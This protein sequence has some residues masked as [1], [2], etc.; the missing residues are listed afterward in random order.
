MNKAL[1]F[2][3]SSLITLALSDLLYV[4][5][6]LKKVFKGEFLITSDVKAEIIDRPIQERRFMLEA[7]FFKKLFDTGV[8][9]LYKKDSIEKEREKFLELSN[10]TFKS[11]NES[12]KMVHGG[13]ASCLALYKVVPANKKAVVID[14]RTTRMLCEAPENLRKLLESKLH[15]K[16]DANINN[17][18]AFENIKIFRSCELVLMAYKFGIINLPAKK[19]TI[20]EALMYATKFKGCTVSNKEIEA[21]KKIL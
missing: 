11:D 6:P 20:I 9:S 14:E 17:Y 3:T 1:I 13:E 16:I 21:A 2:D 15:K 4:L 18:S 19:Q 7:L 5:E 10:T 8:L 12:I